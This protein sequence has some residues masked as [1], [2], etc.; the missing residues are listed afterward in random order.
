MCFRIQ[1]ERMEAGDFGRMEDYRSHYMIHKELIQA[2]C[3][4]DVR[5]MHPGPLNREVEISSELADDPTYSLV[6]RQVQNG[7]FMRMAVL[8]SLM[9]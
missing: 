5:A 2:L 9:S 8:D 7:V 1:K 6:L 3:A 4:D